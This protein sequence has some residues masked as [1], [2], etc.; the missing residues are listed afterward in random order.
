MTEQVK[1][2]GEQVKPARKPTKFTAL[3]NLCT[4]KGQVKKG[5]KFTCTAGEAEKFKQA[6]AI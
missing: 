3:R 1:V 4:S 6:K 5:N 2:E